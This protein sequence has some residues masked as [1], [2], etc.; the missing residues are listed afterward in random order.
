MSTNDD[1]RWEFAP[2]DDEDEGP[3]LD[4]GEIDE[5]LNRPVEPYPVPERAV[6]APARER[7]GA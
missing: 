6:K 1:P 2:D 7:Q 5:I 3:G 4:A